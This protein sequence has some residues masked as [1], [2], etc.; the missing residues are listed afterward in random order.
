MHL[1]NMRKMFDDGSWGGG[2]YWNEFG[3][4]VN[5]LFFYDVFI[6]S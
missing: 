2:V 4:S 3:C 1:Y 6:G 5:I